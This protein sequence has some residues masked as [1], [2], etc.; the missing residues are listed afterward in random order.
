MKGISLRYKLLAAL[1]IIPVVGISLF[2]LL[3]VNIFEKDKIAY[4]F[5]SSLSVSKTRAARVASE[6]SSVISLTQAL[7]LSYRTDTKNLAESGG[8]YFEHEAKFEAFRLYAF[9]PTT[10]KY[11]LNVD[12]T[13]SASKEVVEGNVAVYKDVMDRARENAVAVSRPA[14]SLT[15][16]IVAARFGETS[17]PK[18]LIAVTT[19]DGADLADVFRDHGPY[20]SFLS[21]TDGMSVFSSNHRRSIASAG[22]VWTPA[23][24]WTELAKRKT[25]EGIAEIASPNK[26]KFLA[27]Y[28]EVGVG[29]L[30]VVSMV[31]KAAALEA[32]GVLLRKSI[33]F[34]VV[35]I[36][37]TA[38]IAVF[39]SS[40]LTSSLSRLSLAT[41]KIA[42]GDFEVRVDANSGGELGILARSFNAMAQ[43]VSRLMS[44][45]AEKARME[46]EL[47]TAKTVQETLF[48]NSQA[49]MGEVEIAGYYMPASECGGDWWYY[50]ESHD[51]VFIWIGDATGHGAPAALLTSAARAVASVIHFGP[52]RPVSESLGILNQAI[53]DTSKGKMMMTFFL[54][55]INKT[56]GE[57]TYANASHEPPYLLHK[58]ES[59]PT[60]GDFIPLNDINNPRLG[61]QPH[62]EFKQSSVQLEPGDRIVFYT[63]GVTDVKNIADK[64]WGERKFLKSLSSCLYDKASA[65]P[66]LSDLVMHLEEYREDT[67]LDDDVT[68][69]VC[70][71]KGAA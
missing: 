71:Y 33:F 6:I 26:A 37:I 36:S 15:K 53:C 16:M 20:T 14:N 48:P 19:F 27:S 11:D 46:T 63:D 21:R 12:L 13:K 2:L 42:E 61:E 70:N 57:M 5:D 25:P 39:A 34:F 49:D 8:Y 59:E 9:N 1:T 50:C 24:I 58:T 62:F 47:A 3:A 66:A 60:R 7:V 28:T 31:D 67:P 54:A 22:P 44:E 23:E 52:D 38:I 51:Q 41:R 18:H 64:T 10:A 45:T 40:G 56:T 43:E 35:V 29:D 30:V 68:L 17:D 69:V 32:V 65:G 4:I 55:S